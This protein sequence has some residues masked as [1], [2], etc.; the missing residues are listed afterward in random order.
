MTD[1]E[2]ATILHRGFSASE[3]EWKVQ[4]S[5]INSKGVWAQVVPY[6]SARG[7]M[8][9][10][11]EAFGPLGFSVT[12]DAIMVG[13]VA[14]MK[15]TITAY[16]DKGSICREDV[17][18][19]TDFEALKG[20]A[21]G[22]LKRAA[23]QFGVGRYLYDSPRFYAMIGPDDNSS[24]L[25]N[26]ATHRD[27]TTKQETRYRWG[28]PQEAF[29]W[30]AAT[31]GKSNTSAPVAPAAPAATAS[32]SPA[33]SMPGSSA[34]PAAPSPSVKMPGK[35]GKLFKDKQGKAWAG[36]PIETVPDYVLSDAH[37]YLDYKAKQP[38][39]RYAREAGRDADLIAVEIERR[40]G[41]PRKM[42]QDDAVEAGPGLEEGPEP[43][44]FPGADG[45]EY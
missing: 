34:A 15:C 7:V 25:P 26:R 5:G 36:E 44:E 16:T 11:N 1:Q 27:K 24:A 41:G 40:A 29:E 45:G 39:N 20:A 12:F 35:A 23:V 3:L 6:V 4:S 13:S 18:E 33:P 30:I 10:L 28:L 32:P 31:S 37:D 42:R 19:A 38:A 21:S 22:A 17:S 14:G 43:E 9:R 2:I 8:D